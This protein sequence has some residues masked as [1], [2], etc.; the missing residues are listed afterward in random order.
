MFLTSKL[1]TCFVDDFTY[2]VK[3]QT[4]AYL[5]IRSAY[6]SIG[7]YILNVKYT[8][9]GICSQVAFKN[10]RTM[11]FLKSGG[12]GNNFWLGLMKD[13]ACFPNP[14]LTPLESSLGGGVF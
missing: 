10:A 5:L 13:A 14:D 4:I 12:A 6:V 2:G 11:F 9:Y 1:F 7:F 8:Q 3:S